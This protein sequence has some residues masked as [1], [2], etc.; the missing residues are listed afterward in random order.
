MKA[1]VPDTG[2]SSL[3]DTPDAKPTMSNTAAE[4][5]AYA[6]ANGIELPTKATKSQMLSVI[7]GA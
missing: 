5:R 2:V 3:S 7:E 6:K 4:I 1:S